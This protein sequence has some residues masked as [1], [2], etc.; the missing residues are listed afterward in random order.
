MVLLDFIKFN[1]LC[2]V[3]VFKNFVVCVIMYGKFEKLCN[4]DVYVFIVI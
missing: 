4:L 2:Y 1:G 3:F